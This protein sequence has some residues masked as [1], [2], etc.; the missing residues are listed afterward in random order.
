MLEVMLRLLPHWRRN[1]PPSR[2]FSN[3]YAFVEPLGSVKIHM[4]SRP[5]RLV[6][7]FMVS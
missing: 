1:M 7:W 2:M 5:A 3:Q 4:E 6:T